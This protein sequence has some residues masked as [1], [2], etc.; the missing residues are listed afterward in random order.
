MNLNPAC[1]EASGTNEPSQ[2]PSTLILTG[3]VVLHSLLYIQEFSSIAQREHLEFTV[4]LCCLYCEKSYAGWCQE[5][6][7]GRVHR[8]VVSVISGTGGF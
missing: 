4:K 6:A 7:N 5:V 2:L 3:F 8:S 1:F